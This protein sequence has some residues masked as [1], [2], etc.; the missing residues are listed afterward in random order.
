MSND[1]GLVKQIMVYSLEWNSGLNIM[2]S[3]MTLVTW[4]NRKP[5]ALFLKGDTHLTVYGPKSLMRTPGTS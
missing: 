5:Q 3:G 4:Q 1:R 2:L